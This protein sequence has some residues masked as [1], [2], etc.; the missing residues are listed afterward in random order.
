MFITKCNNPSL[1]TSFYVDYAQDNIY[2]MDIAIILNNFKIVLDLIKSY[3][4]EDPQL[5]IFI[6]TINDIVISRTLSI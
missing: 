4:F 3:R 1:L 5:K 2:F 6:E